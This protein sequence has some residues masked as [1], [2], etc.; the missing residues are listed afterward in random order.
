[1]S[2]TVVVYEGFLIGSVVYLHVAGWYHFII[3]GIWT[4]F[5]FW[6]LLCYKLICFFHTSI[7]WRLS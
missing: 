2:Y 6:L 5:I 1:M 4:R 3:C 7:Y